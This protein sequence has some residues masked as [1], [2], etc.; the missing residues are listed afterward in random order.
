MPKLKEQTGPDLVILGSGTIVSQFTDARLIDEYQLVVNP[1]VLG[2][3]RTMFSA[4]KGRVG[5]IL[6][7][8]RRFSNGNVFLWYGPSA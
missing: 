4:V 5:L 8:T 6:K 2:A 7:Q 1:I 3:G